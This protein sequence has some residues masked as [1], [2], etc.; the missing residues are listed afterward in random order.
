MILANVSN[1]AVTIQ[2]GDRIAQMVIS[3]HE[4]AEWIEVASL[5]ETDRGS[6]GFG[7]TGMN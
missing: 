1:E 3:R 7:S 6:G 4:Q 5:S 2:H